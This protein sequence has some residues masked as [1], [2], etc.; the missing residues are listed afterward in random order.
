MNIHLIPT[1]VQWQKFKW[2]NKLGIIASY[3]GILGFLVGVFQFIFVDQIDKKDIE[4]LAKSAQLNDIATQLN[5]L[6]LEINRN[7]NQTDTIEYPGF[8]FNLCALIKKNPSKGKAFI[9]DR[10]NFLDKERLS[11][12]LNQ[13]NELCF[14]I[15]DRAG[16]NHTMVIKN[17]TNGFYFD[18]L[19]FITC[20]YGEKEN[21]SFQRVIING[22]EI[23]RYTFSKNFQLA[24]KIKVEGSTLGADLNGENCSNIYWAMYAMAFV[25]LTKSQIISF[26]K[27]TRELILETKGTLKKAGCGNYLRTGK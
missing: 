15:L 20:E 9:F 12:Y 13:D 5:K 3:L 19:L 11:C 16:E 22:K 21:R 14:R 27:A 25:T 1:K 2:Y 23:E 4:P 10:G 24:D 6:S 26:E 17:D 8:S 7:L 18:R